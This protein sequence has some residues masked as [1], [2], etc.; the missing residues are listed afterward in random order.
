MA[1]KLKFDE[2]SIK[3]VAVESSLIFTKINCT[4]CKAVSQ[5]CE[6]LTLALCCTSGCPSAWNNLNHT[7]QIFNTFDAIIFFENM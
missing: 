7:G 5:N 4:L 1:Q 6:N 3:F 2:L